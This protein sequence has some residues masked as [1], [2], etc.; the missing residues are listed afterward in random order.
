MKLLVYTYS[1]VTSGAHRQAAL[2]MLS[3]TEALATG[4]NPKWVLT[5]PAALSEE[6][7]SYWRTLAAMASLVEDG[8]D[9]EV[10]A[11]LP[12]GNRLSCST[13]FPAPCLQ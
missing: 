12:R 6:Q 11:P 10:R 9:V 1:D 4:A 13:C 2:T 8:Q 5:V 7:K 3:G